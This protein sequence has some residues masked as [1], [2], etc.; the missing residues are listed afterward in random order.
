MICVSTFRL[1]QFAQVVHGGRISYRFLVI[2]WSTILVCVVQRC[3]YMHVAYR[4]TLM[5]V[6]LSVPS[7]KH[8]THINSQIHYSYPRHFDFASWNLII[9]LLAND[10]K[11]V[12][13]LASVIVKGLLNLDTAAKPAGRFES[14]AAACSAASVCVCDDNS[15]YAIRSWQTLFRCSL[16]TMLINIQFCIY[17]TMSNIILC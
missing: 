8:I 15:Y 10:A 4:A 14:I 1:R 9:S 13:C 11:S 17:T 16:N 5:T 12:L 2:F 3:H 7:H 6:V